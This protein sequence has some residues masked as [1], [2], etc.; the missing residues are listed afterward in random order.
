MHI[1]MGNNYSKLLTT[2]R[3]V[4]C[5]ASLAT[6]SHVRAAVAKLTPVAMNDGCKEAKELV[7]V[8]IA[9]AGTS[10]CLLISRYRVRC[11]L[12]DYVLLTHINN[13]FHHCCLCGVLI[14]PDSH[15]RKQD[16]TDNV[17]SR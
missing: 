4:T 9:H 6:P 3:C 16:G 7:R 10:T 8:P 15:L 11:Q 17:I 12:S 5:V 14:F 1:G 2:L 13:C